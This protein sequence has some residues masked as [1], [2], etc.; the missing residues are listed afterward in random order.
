M[1]GLDPAI[2]LFEKGLLRRK[3]DTRV[4]P[5]Y[6]DLGYGSDNRATTSDVVRPSAQL[7]TGAG[8]T[9]L[10]SLLPHPA[11]NSSASTRSSRVR[12]TSGQSRLKS[13]TSRFMSVLFI[14][15]ASAASSTN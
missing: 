12:V 14:A 1:A 3:M 4:K 6:D 11:L 13:A 10:R 8:T 2:H 9:L 5:A 15:R 7:R